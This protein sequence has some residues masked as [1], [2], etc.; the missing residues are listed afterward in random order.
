L[1]VTDSRPVL[2]CCWLCGDR[3]ETTAHH[4]WTAG[5]DHA[6][7]QHRAYLLVDPDRVIDALTVS[8]PAQPTH[9]RA[10]VHHL[11]VRDARP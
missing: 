11:P 9:G 1:N 8:P 10:A 6:L 5:I 2:L 3:I 4:A 7:D